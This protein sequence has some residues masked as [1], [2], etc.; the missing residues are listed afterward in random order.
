M[1][2]DT[3]L[4]LLKVERLLEDSLSKCVYKYILEGK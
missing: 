1:R 3:K 4:L 2:E